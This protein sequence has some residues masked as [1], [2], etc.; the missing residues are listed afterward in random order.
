ME[1]I[2]L[3][4]DDK[5]L[6]EFDVQIQGITSEKVDVKFIIESDGVDF[7]FDAKL[8][9]GTVTVDIPILS[10]FL[11][12]KT[13]S[14]KMAF[15]VE[16]RYFEPLHILTELV[17]P[18]SITSTI[19]KETTKKVVKESSNI[20]E[21]SIKVSTIKVTPKR[22]LM[23]RMRDTLPLMKDASNVAEIISIYKKDVLLNE[24]SNVTQKD[25]LSF[26]NSYCKSEH[27][28]SFKEY[29]S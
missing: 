13:Y 2:T 28:K 10:K 24:T 9:N 20:D 7:A 16:G 29:I 8:E 21:S 6:L 26:I 25:A 18:M 4:V 17:Q 27:N 3:T 5:N 14:A 15:V 1:Q 23:E 22:D 11:E 12:P 19:K